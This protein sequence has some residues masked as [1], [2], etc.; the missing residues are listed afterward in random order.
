MATEPNSAIEHP[1]L[2]RRLS[3]AP[4]R[5]SAPPTPFAEALDREEQQRGRIILRFAAVVSTLGAV[6][7]QLVRNKSALHW[8]MTAAVLCTALLA[9]I[10]LLTSRGRRLSI[11]WV[12][13]IA[14]LGVF[15]VHAATAYLGVLSPTVTI[16]C[17]T[18]Y[19][20]G[21]VRERYALVTIYGFA[22]V[23]YLL[24]ATLAFI[25]VLPL[26]G[27]VVALAV[28]N[29]RA[30]VGFA[31]LVEMTFLFTIYLA[32]RTRSATLRAFE[33]IEQARREVDQRDALLTEARHELDRAR[34]ALGIGH[35]TGHD[36]A[37]YEIRSLIGR[38]AMGEVYE[39]R[40][41]AGGRVA[42]KMLHPHLFED[43]HAYVRFERESGVG[44][45]I[46]SR[47][48]VHVLEASR[49][50]DGTPFVAMELLEGETLAK[51]LNERGQLDLRE[52]VDLVEEVGRGLHA[53]HEVG[54][55]HRDVKPQNLFHA[56]QPSG[57]IW[58]ILDFGVAKLGEELGSLTGGAAVGTPAYMSPEQTRG[59]SVD[60]RAD[61]F[62]LGAIAYRALT[63]RPAFAADD[64]VAILYRVSFV[65]PDR[66]S[67]FVDVPPEVDLVLALALA[68][69]PG[70]RFE[71]TLEFAA[72]LRGAARGELESKRRDAAHAL[73]HEQPWGSEL[74][75]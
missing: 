73:L 69:D 61:L 50:E 34:G 57:R 56:E 14:I 48:A 8:L 9:V 26:T 60:P 71:S 53:A 11:L 51:V 36:I 5:P 47:H 72:A 45:S 4:P 2:R 49:G 25:G 28:D 33:E 46:D 3:D 44:R 19:Y 15:C 31:L 52:V 20:W 12:L 66:P 13:L 70:R 40:D 74:E 67:E 7:L 27:S 62:A 39:G 37:G 22:A 18:L 21:T 42:L 38:G 64:E 24:L 59:Q 35:H 6:L 16:L 55:V 10:G 23:G 41:R 68:K 30:L 63:G 75:R 54:V 58:K 65:Q 17:V 43:E 29:K 1:D 32:R